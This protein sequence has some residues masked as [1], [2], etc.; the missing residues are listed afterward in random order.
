[1]GAYGN[2]WYGWIPASVPPGLNN[3]VAIA[4]TGDLDLALKR[5]GTVVGWNRNGLQTVPDGLH[6]VVAIAAGVNTYNVALVGTGQPFTGPSLTNRTVAYGSTSYLSISAT[7][8]WPLSYQW[9]F[10]G[11]P[12]AGATNPVLVLP[13]VTF[14][15]TGPYSVVVSDTFGHSMNRGEAISVAPLV[16]SYQPQNSSVFLGDTVRLS[17]TAEAQGPFAYQWFFN[18]NKLAGANSSELVINNA[19]LNQAGSYSVLVTNSL[20]QIQSLPANVAVGLVATWGDGSSAQTNPPAGLSDAVAIA[21]GDSHALAL[22]P[23]GTVLAWGADWGGQIDAPSGLNNA[24]AIAAGS[25][26]SLA[27]RADGTVIAWGDYGSAATNVPLGLKTV[28]AIAANGSHQLALKADGTVVG[29]G[30]NTYGQSTV[31]DGLTNVVAIAAGYSHSMALR[32][33]GSIVAWGAGRTNTGV[34]AGFGQSI[35][36]V[37]LTNAVAIAAGASHSLALTADGRLVGWGYNGD[38]EINVPHLN[39]AVGVAAG[40]SHSLALRAN[41]TVVAWGANWAGQ[42]NIPAT[43]SGVA[44]LAGGNSFSMGLIANGPPLVGSRSSHR[45][46]AIGQTAYLRVN[47]VGGMPLH[48]QWR[49]NGADLAGA[50]NAVLVI[51]N[52][53]MSQAGTYSVVVSNA[54][55]QVISST[56]RLDVPAMLL[57]AQPQSQLA[58]LGTSVTFSAAA[59]GAGPFVYQWRFNGVSLPDATNST[60]VLTNIQLGQSGLYDIVV[61]N[62]FQSLT[63]TPATLSVGVVAQWAYNYYSV[64]PPVVP[65]ATNTVAISQSDSH[66]LLLSSDGTVTAWGDNYSGQTIVPPGLSNIVAVASGGVHSLALRNDGTVVA[67]GGVGNPVGVTN[68]PAGLSNVVAIAAGSL[69]SLALRADGTVVSWGSYSYNNQPATVPDGLSNIVAIA[70]G[71]NH[72]LALKADG[73]VTGWGLNDSGQASPPASLRNVIAVAGG[74]NHSLALRAD[75]TVTAW[76]AQWATGLPTGVRNAVAIAAGQ[77]WSLVLRSDGTVVSAGSI[78]PASVPSGLNQVVAI[79]GGGPHALAL[80]GAGPPVLGDPLINRKIAYGSTTF[81][82]ATAVGAR[83]SSFQW[84]FNGNDLIGATNALLTLTNLTFDQAGT[85]SVVVSNAFGQVTS[86]NMELSVASLL[87]GSYPSDQAG[88]IGGTV[89][90]GVTAVGQGPFSYQWQF[91]GTDLVGQTNSSLLLS[92]AQRNQAGSYTVVISNGSES[93]VS[94]PALVSLA[95]VVGWGDDSSGQNNVPPGLS[96]IIAVA[97]GWDQSLALTTYGTVIAWGAYW[98]TNSM[99]QGLS[100]VTAIAAGQGYSLVLKSDG[101]VAGWG[102]ATPAVV[103]ANVTNTV[104][105]AAGTSH[106]LALRDDGSV[107]AWGDNSSGKTSVPENLANIVAVA[108]GQSHSVALRSDGRVIAWGDNSSGQLAV[109]AS[110]GKVIALA[111]GDYH[112]LALKSDGTVV[113]WGANWSGQIS[114][115]GWNNIVAIACGSQFSMGLRADGSL[116]MVGDNSSKQLLRPNGVNKVAAI[117]AGGNHSLALLADGPPLVANLLDQ[118]APYGSAV[119]LRAVA[120][121][122]RPISYQ[123]RLDGDNIPGATNAVLALTNVLFSDAGTYSVIASNSLGQTSSRGMNLDVSWLVIDNQ[124]QDVTT[125]KGGDAGFSVTSEGYGPSTYQ[126]Q[127]NGADLPGSTNRTLIITNAQL[128]QNGPYNVV[129]SNFLGELKSAYGNLSVGLVAC[130]GDNSSGQTNV[131]AGLTNV[132][133][134][135]GGG[136]HSLALNRDGTVVGW[137]ANDEQ[138]P[139]GLTNVVAIA[140]GASHSLALGADGSVTG[141]GG[142]WAGQAQAPPDATNIIAI[143][144]GDSHSLAL[145]ADGT[146]A[147]W[148][149]DSSGQTNVPEGLA[150]VVALA[151]GSQHSVALRTD[152][153]VV[154]W[155]DNSQGQLRVPLFLSNV[156]AIAAG[157]YH[158]IALRADG[159]VIGWGAN[160]SGQSTP[161][162]GLSK[163]LAVACGSAHSIALKA[164]GTIVTWGDNYAGQRNMPLGLRKVV[165]IA[166]GSSHS[167]ALVGDG[168]PVLTTPMLGKTVPFDAPAYFRVTAA[169]DGPLSYQWRYQGVDL[170]GATDA[171][172]VLTNALFSQAGAYSVVVSNAVGQVT[173]PSVNL[174][175]GWLQIVSEPQDVST[176]RGANITLTVDA[177]GY[178]LGYQWQVDGDDLSGA[179]N[180][181]LVLNNAQAEQSGSYSVVVSNFLGMTRS[182]DAQVLISLIGAW[183]ADSSSGLTNVPPGLTNVLAVAAGA[184]HVLALKGDGTVAAWGA[185]DSQQTDVPANLS[186]VVAIAAGPNR[187]L[188]LTAD[189]T[190][191]AWGDSG[192]AQ[193]TMPPN[194]TGVVAIACGATHTLA[195]QSGGTVTAWGDNSYGQ[196]IVPSSLSNTV[197]IAAGTYHSLALQANGTVVAWGSYYDGNRGQTVTMTAPT[198][199]TNVI[200]IASG[201]HH[202]L[203]LRAARTILGWGDNSYGQQTPPFGGVSG[204]VALAAGDYY[205]L[206]LKANGTLAFWGDSSARPAVLTGLRNVTAIS[207]RGTTLLALLG[208]GLPVTAAPL[209]NPSLT[210]SG[211]NLFVPTQSGRVYSLEFNDSLQPDAWALLPLTAGNGGTIKLTDPVTAAGQRFFRVRRW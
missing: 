205:S 189:G 24:V 79:S 112:T 86:S 95:S 84:R 27:L 131:P 124:P 108:A 176:I 41:G 194:L 63:S 114:V 4:A 50:T 58:A 89:V 180:R 159:T 11:V 99:P 42:V 187:S 16:L 162:R 57:T 38:G 123:W 53:K 10:N 185:D 21:A 40:G 110:L 101:T 155:G 173:S 177:E 190:L 67:W 158:S 178:G 33:D 94:K 31:P 150:N 183:T 32:A 135:A 197:A 160:Y 76:G 44:A 196:T 122:S 208:D 153:R 20:G 200:A 70:C 46:V 175:V 191:T 37:N 146:V 145:T 71:L 75:G 39:D 203:A 186:D 78:S 12:I 66:S 169:G 132:M 36:P 136:N 72:S 193:R 168:A 206:A 117:A 5:D 138:V 198:S 113:G 92:N 49:F 172:L 25:S 129:L 152:G 199:L 201:A 22:K 19:Q 184:R 156:V 188:A 6:N 165:G 77:D 47:A 105:I 52:A 73:T 174:D 161:P 87:I 17:V 88:F 96:N 13:Q 8:A 74:A 80:L 109:P 54:L 210:S 97:C 28:V 85:Y 48:Y 64:V 167:M 139:P 179:T 171:I 202:A 195:L 116:L 43:L 68:V 182:R 14:Q 30:D 55:G 9:M 133:A 147:A 104:A 100:N 148:G 166:A 18:G 93:L 60:L 91:N 209:F 61:Q 126:W 34:N 192:S 170:P 141:W 65:G 98:A 90:L 137:G 81:V 128:P 142:N 154:S 83:P 118:T 26:Q 107:V 62:G 51:A 23:D 149:D 204:I 1:M 111:A 121:G 56:I 134:L 211:F 125:F 35:V 69:H 7:G 82:R 119:F 45:A 151:A 102:Y 120:L 163:V 127:F 115:G 103:P 59:V 164:D 106:A 3:V 157:S 207:G 2:G 15:N 181:T 144:C 140:A 130:F 143:S 29:W